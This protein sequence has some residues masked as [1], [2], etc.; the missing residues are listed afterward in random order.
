[1]L[2][3]VISIP[4]SGNVHSVEI[5]PTPP[6]EGVTCPP[7]P[8]VCCIFEIETQEFMNISLEDLAVRYAIPALV[9]LRNSLI[10]RGS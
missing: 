9:A 7:S 10:V 3:I 2:N 6:S 8:M 5:R 1:M 4:L